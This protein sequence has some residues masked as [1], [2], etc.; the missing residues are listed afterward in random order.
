MRHGPH[1]KRSHQQ[2]FVAVGTSLPSCYL[3]TI[4]TQTQRLSFDKTRTA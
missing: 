1:R 3:S 4:D 2:F